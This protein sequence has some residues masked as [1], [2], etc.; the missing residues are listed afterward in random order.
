MTVYCSRSGPPIGLFCDLIPL[1]A[2]PVFNQFHCHLNTVQ[3]HLH[4]NQTHSLHVTGMETVY[5]M[6][7]FLQAIVLQKEEW[8]AWFEGFGLNVLHW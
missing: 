7:Q 8:F 5:D 3:H 4:Q 2:A 6:I 1:A